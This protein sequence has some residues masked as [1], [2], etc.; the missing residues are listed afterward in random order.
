MRQLRVL[1]LKLREEAESDP[2]TFAAKWDDR[3]KAAKA[4]APELRIALNEALKATTR[5]Q[6]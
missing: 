2:E 4:V 6:K 1:A 3:D 5:P